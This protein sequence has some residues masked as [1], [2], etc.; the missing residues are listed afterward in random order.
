MDGGLAETLKVT[1]LC[2]IR[3]MINAQ[4]GLRTCNDA[5]NNWLPLESGPAARKTNDQTLKASIRMEK[6]ILP[7]FVPS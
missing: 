4:R 7:S 3:S 1:K 6:G 2:H 5:N